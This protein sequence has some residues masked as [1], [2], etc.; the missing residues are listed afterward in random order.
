LLREEQKRDVV[1]PEPILAVTLP[2]S[3]TSSEPDLG[4]KDAVISAKSRGEEI[5]GVRNIADASQAVN[6]LSASE[7]QRCVYAGIG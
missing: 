3:T 6:V 4:R 5:F 1:A 2:S 7:H